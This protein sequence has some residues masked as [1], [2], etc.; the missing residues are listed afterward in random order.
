MRSGKNGG[1]PHLVT[2]FCYWC[3]LG[4]RTIG[5]I[6]CAMTLQNMKLPSG[7]MQKAREHTQRDP[8]FEA[9]P[10]A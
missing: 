8:P 5:I 10:L 2:M 7:T 4:K 9:Y 1:M 3:D 6:R